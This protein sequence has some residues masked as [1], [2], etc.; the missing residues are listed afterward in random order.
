VNGLS[1]DSDSLSEPGTPGKNGYIL[2][3]GDPRELEAEFGEEETTLPP[4]LRDGQRDILWPDKY[5]NECWSLSES[6]GVFEGKL[7]PM[8]ERTKALVTREAILFHDRE[9]APKWEKFRA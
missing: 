5:L 7:P 8:D 2:K 3:V 9:K 4:G 6:S 1:S